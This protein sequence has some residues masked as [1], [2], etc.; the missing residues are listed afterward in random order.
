MTAVIQRRGFAILD[1]PTD[2]RR[3]VGAVYAEVR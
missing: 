3:T 2:V 1:G